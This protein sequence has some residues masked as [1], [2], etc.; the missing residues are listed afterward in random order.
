M[1]YKSFDDAVA[2]AKSNLLV[3]GVDILQHCTRT[4]MIT[5]RKLV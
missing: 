4:T 1:R 5:F 3:E 2:K